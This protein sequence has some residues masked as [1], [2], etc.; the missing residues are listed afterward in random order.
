MAWGY[1]KHSLLSTLNFLK[2]GYHAKT[3]AIMKK[4][5]CPV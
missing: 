5:T 4:M 3:V 2:R 1:E